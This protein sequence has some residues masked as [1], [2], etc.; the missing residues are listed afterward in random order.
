M[1]SVGQ[2]TRAEILSQPEVWATVITEVRAQAQALQEFW[3]TGQFDSII[4]TGCGSTYYLSLAAA[5]FAQTLL[6]IP[7]RGW[8]ASELW[9]NPGVTYEVVTSEPGQG[10]HSGKRALKVVTPKNTGA[11]IAVQAIEVAPGRE[12]G[13]GGDPVMQQLRERLEAM[14]QSQANKL[15]K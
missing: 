15:L 6:G 12:R 7:A 10:V 5:A 14:L 2:H 8:P 4:F 13:P 11:Q 9:L 3:N 1:P